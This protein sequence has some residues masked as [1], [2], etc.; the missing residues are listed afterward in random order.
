MDLNSWTMTQKW[1][2]TMCLVDHYLP[3]T[4]LCERLCNLLLNMLP[5]A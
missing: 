1:V 4:S 2:V 5:S 3:P